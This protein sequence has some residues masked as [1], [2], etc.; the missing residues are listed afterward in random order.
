MAAILSASSYDKVKSIG[1][2]GLGKS[3]LARHKTT[4]AKVAIKFLKSPPDLEGFAQSL[5]QVS[6]L[7][8]PALLPI[9]GYSLPDAKKNRPAAI[10]TDYLPNGS[11]SNLIGAHKFE[12]PVLQ[13]TLFLGLAEGLRYLHSLG[14]SHEAL[15]PS[16]ILF[17]SN[18]EPQVSHYALTTLLPN[19][20]RPYPIFTSEL[21]ALDCDLFCYGAIIYSIL[22]DQLFDGDRLPD[23][24]ASIPLHYAHLITSCWSPETTCFD[25]IVMQF[26]NGDYSLSLS[27]SD[28]RKTRYY[29]ARVVPSSFNTCSIVLAFDEIDRVDDSR[30]QLRASLADVRAELDL[31]TAKLSRW[32]S[33][34]PPPESEPDPTRDPSKTPKTP[35]GSNEH[36]PPWTVP[37]R[38]RTPS[39]LG[40]P[41]RSRAEN[42]LNDF[43]M[44]PFEGIFARWTADHGDNIAKLGIVVITGNTFEKS[45]DAELLEIVNFQWTKCWTS[46]NT[47]NSWIQFD[48]GF[49]PLT[50]SHY[51]LK[52]YPS[53]RGYSHLKSWVLEGR[54]KNG[55]WVELDNRQDCHD[56]NGRSRVQM[57]QVPV[58]MECQIL[59]IRQTGANHHGD[60]Y[61]ILTNVEFFGEIS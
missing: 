52:T 5:A 56:L 54:A 27:E 9:S 8:H 4:Q 6:S 30:E 47:P 41:N 33:A 51:T 23:L 48:F 37:T 15:T 10:F 19:F 57:F 39:T 21:S 32:K 58:P 7:L 2:G 31:L 14:F 36:I 17:D 60:H 40:S 18:F 45:R 22:T 13:T 26:I 24:P 35:P 46:A 59:R 61:L 1:S 53:A 49:R 11:L 43:H 12:S 29:E 34:P 25:D 3:Y 42:S 20:M 44:Q 28:L 38:E 55:N 50:V 16:N